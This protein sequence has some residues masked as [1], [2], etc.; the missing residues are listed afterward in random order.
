MKKLLPLTL[1]YTVINMT[2][3]GMTSMA[4]AD[5]LLMDSIM[6]APPNS[7]AGLIRPTRSMSMDSVK[8]TFGEPAEVYSTVGE[9]PI[10]R[11]EYPGYSVFFEFDRV[12]TT[13]VHR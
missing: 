1:F 11:W 4:N 13:V 10:T 6:D 8:S 2:L 7:P 9:P 12:I 5:T 3:L